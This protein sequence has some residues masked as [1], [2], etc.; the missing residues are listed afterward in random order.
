MKERYMENVPQQ[1]NTTPKRMTEHKLMEYIV[2]R[3]VRHIMRRNRMNYIVQWYGYTRAD[4]PEESA[5]H[6]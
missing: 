1:S 4:D 2:Y 6:I 3:I 5:Q